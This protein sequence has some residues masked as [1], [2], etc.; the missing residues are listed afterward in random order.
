MDS[1][2]GD[3]WGVPLFEALEP[4]LLLN[5]DVMISEFM[6]RNDETLLDG[7]NQYSDWLEIHN[8]GTTAVDLTGWRLKDDNDTWTFPSVSLGPGEFRT[9]FASNGRENVVDPVDPY[10]DP[11]GNLHTNFKLS[12]GGEYLGLFD[13]LGDVVHEY[14]EYPQQFDDISY[15]IAQDVSTTR[16]VASGDTARYIIPDGDQG[17]WMNRVFD[18]SAWDTGQTGIGF[19]DL[20]SGFAVTNFK[21]NVSVGN[22]GVAL[23]VIDNPAMQSYVVEENVP[24]INFLNSGGGGNYTAGQ[25][26]YPGFVGAMSNFVIEATALITIPTSGNWSFGVNSDDGFSLELDDGTNNFYMEYPNGRGAADTIRTFNMPAGIYNLRLVQFQGSGGASGEFFAAQGSY[27]SF[28][29][30]AFDL[31][32]DTA[33]GGLAVYSEPVDGGGGGGGAFSDLIETNVEDAMEN[34]NA[35]AYVRLPF[36]VSDPSLIESLTLKMKYDDGYIAYL[37]G[38][39]IARKNAPAVS[40]WNSNAIAERTDAQAAAWE[41]VDVSAHIGNLVSAAVGDN[42]LAIQGLNYALDD[43]DF[44]LVPELVEVAY[45]GLGEHFF[46]TGTPGEANI[47]EF[48]LYVEDVEFSHDRGFYYDSFDLTLSTDTVGASIY[49]TTDGSA[50]DESNGTLYGAPIH[51][52]TTT[53]IRS[54]AFKSGYASAN[55]V[56]HSYFFMEDVL[57]QPTDP[58][59]FPASWNGI[60]ANYQVDPDIVNHID[61]RDEIR[62]DMRAIPTVSLVTTVEDMFG[63]SG[64]YANP[65]SRGPS[66]EKPASV[67]WINPDGTTL[68]QVNS[69]VQI[70]GG[71]SRGAGNKKHSFR[72]LFKS[73]YGPTT[74][75]Y[76]I[77]GGESVGEFNTITLRAGFNDRWTNGSSTY[78]QDRWAAERQLASGGLASHGNYVHLY[79]DGLY[80][81]LYN[82]VERPDDAFAASYLGGEKEDYDA[83]N[84]EGLNAGNSTGWNQLRSLANDAANNYAAIEG[85][86]DIPAF[87]DYL[88]INQYGGNWDWPQN[89]WWATYNREGQGKWRFHSWD[90]EGCLRDING[91]RVDQH[92][93]ALGDLYWKL[94]AVPEFQSV[95]ADR[96][97]GLLFNDGALTLNANLTWLAEAELRLYEGIV[98]ESARWGDGY[99]DNTSPRTRDN[100]WIPRLNWLR[101]QYFP[102]RSSLTSGAGSSVLQQYKNVGLYPSVNAPSFSINGTPQHGGTIDSGDSLTIAA[103][104]GTIYYTLDGSDPRLVGGGISPAALIYSEAV[105]LSDG[106]FVKSRAYDSGSGTWS[107]LNEAGYFIDLAPDIRITEIMYNPSDPTAAEIAEGYLNNDDFEYIEIKN[108]SATDTLPLAGLR[109]SNGIDFTFGAVSVGP[110]EFVVVASNTAAFNYRYP[111]FSGTVVGP[112]GAETALNNAGEKIELDSPIGGI[113][114]EFNYGDGWYGHTD[115]EGFSLT[116]RDPQGLSDLWDQ[117]IGWRPSEAWGGSPGYE[118]ALIDPGVIVI[119]EVLAHSDAPFVDTIELFNASASPVDISGWFL[120]DSLGDLTSYQIPAMPPVASGQYVVF[121]GDTHFGA[122]FLLSEHGDDV[123]LSS[124]FSGAAG[125]YREH[126]D[127]GASPNNVSLGVYVKSTGGTDFTLLSG[128]TFGSVNADPYF[129]DLVINELLYHPSD[130]T[131]SEIAAGYVDSSYFEFIEIYN[132]SDI[133]EYTTYDLDKFYLSGG[134]GFTFGWL[135]AADDGRESWTLEPGSTAT[136]DAVLTGGLGT[137]EVL[138]RWDLLDG[139]GNERNLDGLASY[140]ITHNSGTSTVRRDQKPELDDEGPGYIDEFGWVSLGSYDFDG[141]GRVVLTRGTTDPDNWTIADNIKFVRSGFADVVVDDPTLD[142][143]HTANGPT[144]IS[145]DEYVVIVSNLA[146]FDAR[147]DIAA[148]GIPVAGEYTGTL[149]N[150]GEKVKLLRAGSPES[151]PSY[152]QP[153]YR[154]DYVNYD[155][156]IPWPVEADGGGYSLVRLRLPGPVEV[157]GNDP[158]SW[159]AGAYLGTPGL[160]NDLIDTTP[161]IAPGGV[162]P[163]VALT[164]G[165]QIDLTWSPAVDLDSGVDHYVI[166][167]DGVLIGTSETTSFSDTDVSPVTQYRYQISAVNRDQ[168]EGALS[169]AIYVTIP[170]PSYVELPGANTVRIVFTEALVEASAEDVGKYSFSGGAVSQA[171]LTGSNTVE[172]TVAALTVGQAYTIAVDGIDTVSGLLMPDAQEVTFEYHLPTGAILREY[173]TGI[174]GSVVS[175]LTGNGNYPDNPARR[176]YETAFEAPQNWANTYGTRMRGY[177]HPTVSGMYTF[178]IASNDSSDLYLSTDTD[179]A[180]ATKIAYVSGSTGWRNWTAQSG[181]QSDPVFLSAGLTYYIEAIHKENSGD[182]HLAVVWK[183]GAGLWVGPI[184]GANLSP[185]IIDTLDNTGPGAPGNVV[186]Q[187]IDSARMN[188][189][190]DAAVDAESAVAYYV[191]YRDGL[192]V[193]TSLTTSYVDTGLDQTQ[194]YVYSVSAVNADKFEGDPASAASASLRPSILDAVAISATQIVVTFGKEVTEATAELLPGNYTLTDGVGDPVTILLAEWNAADPDQVVITVGGSLSENVIYTIEAQLVEDTDGLLVGPNA[195]VQF[196]YGSLDERLLAWW[197]FDVDNE[198]VAHDLT[199]SGHD[200]AVLGAEWEAGGRIGGAYRFDGSAGDYLVNEYPETFIDGLSAFTFAAWIKADSIG[201]DR[202]F[203]YLRDPNGND[204]YGFRHDAA[205]QNQGNAPNGFRGGIRTTGGTQRWESQSGVQTTEWQHVAITWASGQDIQVYLDAVPIAAGWIDAARFGTIRSSTRLIIGRGTHDGNASWQGLIDDV[206]IYNRALSQVDVTALIDPRPIAQDDSYQANEDGELTVVG[207]G[208]LVNDFDPDPGPA[209]MTVQLVTGVVHGVLDLNSD[210]TFNYTPTPGYTGP[211]GFTYRAYDSDEYSTPATV[212]I[213]VMDAVRVI[214]SEAVDSTHVD[215]LFSTNLDSASAQTLGNYI[216]D[217]GLSVVAATLGPDGRTVSLVMDSEMIGNQPYTLT[218][219]NI[220]DTDGSPHTIVP[221]SEVVVTH[222][223][224]IGADIGQV[225]AP[226]AAGEFA[227]TWS[228]DG[229]GADIWG[230]SDEFHYVYQA[231]SGD[232]TVT[233]RVKSVENTNSWAKSGVMIRETLDSTSPNAFMAVTPG[234]GVSFHRRIAAGQQTTQTQIGGLTAPY[235]VRLVREGNLFTGY[236]SLGGANWTVVGSA[237]IAMSQPE[238]YVGMAVTSHNDGVLCTAQFDNVSI[239]EADYQAPTAYVVDVQPDPRSQPVSSVSI[240]FSEEVFGLDVSDLTLTVNG[241]T[242]LL[243]GEESLTTTDNRTWTLSGLAGLTSASGSYLFTVHA[244]GSSIQDIAGNLMAVD[245]VGDWTTV[246]IGP[247]PDVVNVS[248]DPHNSAVSTIDIAFSEPITGLDIGDLSLTRDGGGNLLGPAQSVTTSDNITWTLDGLSTLTADSGIYTLTL[249]SAG[250]NIQNAA[251]QPLS[252]DASDTWV[253]DTQIPTA[254]ISSVDP[255]P[256]GDPVAQ[257]EITFDEPVT[258]LDAGDLTLTRDG[259]ANLLTGSESLTTSDNVTWILSDLLGLTGTPGGGGGFT[260]FNDQAIG[261][262]THANTTVYAGNGVRV[263]ELKDVVTGLGTGVTLTISQTGV[264]YASSGAAPSVGTDAFNIFNGFVDF[265]ATGGASLEIQAS[266]NDIHTHAFSGLD[267]GNA[268]TYNFHGTAIRGNSGYANRWTIVTI[269]GADSFTADHSSGIGVVTAGLDPNQVAIWVGHNSAAGQGFVAGWTDID[270]GSDGEFSI[271]STQY[272]GPTP[273]VG[274]GTANGTKGYAIAGLRLEEVAPS[275]L[276]GDYVL[277]LN[278]AGSGVQDVAGNEITAD[279]VESWVI[280]TTAPTADIIDV[281]PD[282]RGMPVSQIDIVFSEAVTGLDITDLSLTRDGGGELLTGF[283]SLTSGDGVTWTLSGLQPLT[284]SLGHYTLTLTAAGSGIQNALDYLLDGDAFELWTVDAQGTPTVANPIGDVAVDEDAADTVIDISNV[285]DDVDPGDV[286]TYSLRG[287]TNTDLVT[288]NLA[289][290]TLTL[291]YIANQNG[292]ADITVRATDIV[293][294]WIE[295]VFTVTVNPDNDAPTIVNPIGD[296]SVYEDADDTVVDLATVFNDIDAGDTLVLSVTVNTNSSL[297]TTSVDGSNLTLSYIADQNGSADITV[298]ATDQNGTGLW[299]EDTFTVTVDPV[300][301]APKRINP[302]A[303]LAV[304]EDDPDTIIDLSSVF[305]NVDPGDTLTFLV[306]LN[307]NGGLVATSVVGS[308]LTL[309]YAPDQTGVAVIV[310]RATDS[311]APSLYTEDMFS[312]LVNPV[313][314]AP[315]V[316]GPIGDVIVVE[317]DPDTVVDVSSVFSDVDSGDVLTLSIEDNTNPGLVTADL[318]GSDLTLSYAADQSG[319]SDITIRATDSAAPGL[320]VEHTF[321]VTVNSSN[322]APT[323][324]N[325]ITDLTARTGDPDTVMYLSGVFDDSVAHK[326]TLDYTVVEVDPVTGDETAGSG[327]F[328]YKFTLYGNDGVESVFATTTLTFTGAIRQTKAFGSVDVNDGMTAGIFN[329]I[330]DAGYV[331][332]LDSWMFIGWYAIAPNDTSLTGSPVVL[333]VGTGTAEYFEQKDLVQIVAAGDVQWSGTHSRVG[334]DYPTSG[335]ADANRL[336]YS[337]SNNTDPGLVTASVVGSQLTLDYAP[338]A[339]AVGSAD[340]TIRATD[341]EGAWVEDTFTVTVE[342]SVEVVGRHVFYNNS[343]WDGVTDDDAIASDKT[344]LLPGQTATLANYTNY[345]RGINGV[346]VDIDGMTGTPKASDFTIRVNA[347]DDPNTWSAGPA[348]AVSVRPGEGVGGSDRVTL[349]WSDGAIVNQWVEVT[350]RATGKTGLADPDV[351]YFGNAVG[352]ISGDGVIGE[353]EYNALKSQ[354]GR[355]GGIGTLASDF[356][357]DGRVGLRDFAIMRSRF[358]QEVQAPTIPAPAPPAPAAPEPALSPEVDILAESSWTSD[359]PALDPLSVAVGEVDL[360]T[361]S[362][363]ITTEPSTIRDNSDLRALD[364]DLLSSPAGDAD[365]DPLADILNESPVSLPL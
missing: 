148:N 235:W 138:A 4:R 60:V 139:L 335:T 256:R 145:S 317:N 332:A 74:L 219:S 175:N 322:L 121:Y 105:A 122:D 343:A 229:S 163:Q 233:A 285:F 188:V 62:D 186:A 292:S 301:D 210:G 266:Q 328:L 268:I 107:A 206:R 198:I 294:N 269:L 94:R 194:S 300:N 85:M 11:A 279:V 68:F 113:I 9:I 220:Q 79:V 336:V 140:A 251:L 205:L 146:A 125:G 93:S 70:V 180:N 26:D 293:G 183:R 168:F 196:V 30:A 189:T 106:A 112:F 158:A 35:S 177:I 124:N 103:P 88:I 160:V 33:N 110:G 334:A 164:P 57:Q 237:T 345:S 157:Y 150:N 275:G 169:A 280:D 286:L 242:N 356:D 271:V 78:F 18:D 153:Y 252:I 129:E 230:N 267:D 325:E 363:P 204:E 142:S 120:S 350:V 118:D 312:V 348:P 218:I 8:S 141:S 216:V 315:T 320:W 72:L 232:F 310:V 306:T 128:H 50:P 351:F 305:D 181:Q 200:L 86:L 165:T 255:D 152:H 37:N 329:D 259:G 202:G 52:T 155:D 167:R 42:V 29:G 221:N 215:L 58:A 81:G 1:A 226:G 61:Y 7:D 307:T 89:N 45:L 178:S 247:I 227:G 349:V 192:E 137:Y 344:A 313:N 84:I 149:S 115:G 76:P 15:G 217:G 82:P 96:V 64:I 327:L 92:G 243:T 223:T 311:A 102:A 43:G 23:Q 159:A 250:S 228:I 290:T 333:S 91:N 364:D 36:S 331:A 357:G 135:D 66:W 95:F 51:I 238:V 295:D 278:A 20:V 309:S 321:T 190:W 340:I 127:F 59:D 172:L 55:S 97:H 272:T 330:P 56:T 80:W 297:V 187:A 339:S 299:I 338:G 170:G 27:T 116:I 264:N 83:Y 318:V 236:R 22:L 151:A 199:S 171:T 319:S 213:S 31:V 308:D 224:W 73:I 25:T 265:R 244:A 326:P 126:V 71:A 117:K 65:G 201:T 5:G 355:R 133:A 75:K 248:P 337:V 34:I 46:A 49:Y 13:N 134:V 119:N 353:D 111:G 99:A 87:C 154:A 287:N 143:W 100:H 282:P 40:L 156:R 24:V 361:S 359:V 239:V 365:G 207:S 147:Y 323:V 261:G 347:S 54:A 53:I 69:G 314:D 3:N 176:I 184:P 28:N 260:A 214:S 182:D 132:T 32:G 161:P 21:A 63:P 12:G 114:H 108:I 289:G 281:D 362:A 162:L 254:T 10:V 39:E 324:A 303:D 98:G 225:A 130:P 104:L 296:V 173:W 77:F 47:E 44:L 14:D 166:Y 240:V 249:I 263:G 208:V 245:A 67:E 346:M 241:E 276:E 257:V 234:N 41:N 277:Q 352:E 185:Y 203:Y 253:T 17:N 6:A 360:S 354:F 193:G 179:P 16:F 191:V 2:G 283:E 246:L 109:F 284:S 38:V 341:P 136:W 131:P 101:D 274:T 209:P 212:R 174:G 316:T 270:P 123:Y 304:N 302:I 358:G 90:A 197:T 195:A 288:P 258:G 211:D 222:I 298:R 291:S 231:L 48:W 144:T 273:G 19:S 342:S 262:A